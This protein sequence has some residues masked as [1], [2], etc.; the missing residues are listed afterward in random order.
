M[1]HVPVKEYGEYQVHEQLLLEKAIGVSIPFVI[2]Y[3]LDR[4]FLEQIEVRSFIEWLYEAYF[5]GALD[6]LQVYVVEF[7]FVQLLYVTGPLFGV[8]VPF[9]IVIL[10]YALRDTENL[11]WV[12]HLKIF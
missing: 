12:F 1:H 8:F 11:V 9:N 4:F 5:V 7:H 3:P 2:D 6:F 10:N